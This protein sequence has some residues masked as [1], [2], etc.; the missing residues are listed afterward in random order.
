MAH[1]QLRLLIQL[2]NGGGINF[3]AAYW[4]N[5]SNSSDFWFLNT[6]PYTQEAW[7]RPTINP[8]A[9]FWAGIINRESTAQTGLREGYNL[10]FNGSSTSNTSFGSERFSAGTNR[11]AGSLTLD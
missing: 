3:N 7:F 9:N 10:W 11:N 8:G 6:S 5:L 1:L 2:G 4:V